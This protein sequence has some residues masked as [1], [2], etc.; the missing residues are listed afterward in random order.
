[1]D[2]STHD[3]TDQKKARSG[4]LRAVTYVGFEPAYFES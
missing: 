4:R 2:D 3:S 1:M